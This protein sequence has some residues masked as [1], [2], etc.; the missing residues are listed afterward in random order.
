[1]RENI[2]AII[3]AYNAGR[4]LR[5]AIASIQAQSHSVQEI[6]VVDDGS[7]DGT[8]ALA[9]RIAGVTLLQQTNRGVAEARNAGV[10]AARGE[11][12]AFLDAD[13]EWT[14]DAM[15]SNFAALSSQPE[16][17]GVIGLSEEFIC[18]D[19]PAEVAQRYAARSLDRTALFCG[20]M[21]LRRGVME[22]TGPFHTESTGGDFV[23]WFLRAQRAGV[24]ITR[25]PDGV[26]RRRIH[27]NNKMLQRAYTPAIYLK[28]LHEHVQALK[29]KT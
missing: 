8:A 10:Q 2:S 20:A 15:A 24:R 22:T 26:L 23:E 3:P 6:I 28:M 12:L 25:N 11:L 16:A 4:Y 27:G 13:D 17:H 18:P 9:Q 7:T 1:M 14:P 29:S 19:A 5:E 21:L